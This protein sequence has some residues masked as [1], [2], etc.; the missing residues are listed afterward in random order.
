MINQLS[1]TQFR[2][3]LSMDI[4]P[5]NGINFIVGDNGS[6]KTSILEAIYLLGMGRSFRSPTLKSLIHFDYDFAQVF[7]RLDEQVPVGIRL[8]KQAVQIR[9]NKAPL[10]KLSELAS[11]LPLQLIPAN[12]HQFFEQ[13]PRFRRQLVDWGVFHVEHSFLKQWQIY[14]K[15]LQQRNY[16]LRHQLPD[17]DVQVWNKQLTVSGEAITNARKK[18]LEIV[19]KSFQEI[20]A[21]LC[22]FFS[23]ADFSLRYNPGWPKDTTLEQVLL[24]ALHRDKVLG[25]TRSGPHAADWTIRIDGQNPAGLLSR[26]QQKLFFLAV[27]LSQLGL[28]TEHQHHQKSVLLIDDLTS[29][30][31]HEHQQLVLDKLNKL[32]LQ[33]FIT[34]T[35]LSLSA[36]LKQPVNTG[37][38]HVE[39][40]QILTN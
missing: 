27:S 5:A 1:L 14:R 33:T 17:S 2:N 4:T 29:E 26:G 25:Y 6:G 16:A 30:L 7:A 24:S 20:F 15:A 13:G 35:E 8:E 9:L 40:G 21:E 22:P 36:R 12:C 32:P 3:I 34:S 28:L 31:D 19:L 23:T 38:F 10:K 39:H 37:V 11:Y 18:H